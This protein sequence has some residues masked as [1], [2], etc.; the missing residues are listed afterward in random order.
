MLVLACA[1]Q[2][3]SGKSERQAEM[4]KLARKPQKICREA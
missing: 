4:N 3:F 2:T 1:V